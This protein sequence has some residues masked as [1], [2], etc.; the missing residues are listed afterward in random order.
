MSQKPPE[1]TEDESRDEGAGP[2]AKGAADRG[3]RKPVVPRGLGLA[4]DTVRPPQPVVS[5]GEPEPLPDFF[6]D[7]ETL[8]P[9]IPMEQLVEQMM[10]PEEAEE[11]RAFSGASET[12]PP[13]ASDVD[14][15]RPRGDDAKT[16]PPRGD[17]TIP[18]RPLHE[19]KTIPPRGDDTE[20]PQ[21]DDAQTMPPRAD[22]TTVDLRQDDLVTLPPPILDQDT[23]PGVAAGLLEEHEPLYRGIAARESSSSLTARALDTAEAVFEELGVELFRAR[24]TI[25]TEPPRALETEP[26]R[27]RPVEE[28]PR[29][30]PVEEPPRSR[31]VEEPPRSRPVE[32]PPRS[33]PSDEL[34]RSRL[35][36]PEE[37]PRPRSIDERPRI[38]RRLTPARTMKP[39]IDAVPPPPPPSSVAGR[40]GSHRRR[41]SETGS[42]SSE[43]LMSG[44]RASPAPSVPVSERLNEVRS[45]YEAGD[46]RAALALAEAILADAP[47]N[48]GALSYAE[49]SRQMLK[50]KYMARIGDTGLVPRLKVSVEELVRSGLDERGRHVVASIDGV[51][52]ID[53]I[54]GAAGLPTIEVLRVVHD[55]LVSQKLE[56]ATFPRGRR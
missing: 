33:R 56:L 13:P 43:S 11:P 25:E 40:P 50:Q 52:S 41:G 31:P 47:D 46:H 26:P 3:A 19:A 30:R 44:D 17:D 21:R 37:L 49:S 20:P 32:E 23:M 54:I 15:V 36:A 12:I 8:P 42:R 53:D 10:R 22:D 6:E 24:D 1:R 5:F 9:P 34:M 18:P 2:E 38:A 29:S 45:R 14:T 16:I 7:R 35:G 48:I 51:L 28:P 27:S 4:G 39:T 55:L